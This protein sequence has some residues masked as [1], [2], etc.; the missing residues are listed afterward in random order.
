MNWLGLLV[1]I[2]QRRSFFEGFLPL[3]AHLLRRCHYMEC[4]VVLSD[5]YH[6]RG[7]ALVV[8]AMKGLPWKEMLDEYDSLRVVPLVHL[9][10]RHVV[11]QKP[12]FENEEAL[13][14]VFPHSTPLCHRPAHHVATLSGQASNV[15]PVS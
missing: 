3:R 4:S 14:P 1:H 12:V 6:S 7:S 8:G 10:F 13:L 15:S 5:D 2:V 9:L 11:G